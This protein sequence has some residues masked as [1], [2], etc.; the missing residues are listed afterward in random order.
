MIFNDFFIH[1]ERQGHT[2]QN[3]RKKLKDLKVRSIVHSNQAVN[4][5]DR[6]ALSAVERKRETKQET[7]ECLSS[8]VLY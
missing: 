2:G 7:S 6:V 3:G 4:Q 8:P 1:T 5:S